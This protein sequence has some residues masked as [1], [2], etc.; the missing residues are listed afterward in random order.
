MIIPWRLQSQ[1]C[2][3]GAVPRTAADA[4]VGLWFSR[5]SKPDQRVRRGRGRPPHGERIENLGDIRAKN[6]GERA[7]SSSTGDA[8][9][10]APA[11]FRSAERDGNIPIGTSER[12]AG[13]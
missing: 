6:A 8:A 3:G 12:Q 13:I 11:W 1:K 7:S 4:R 9:L 5:V 2:I 10:D